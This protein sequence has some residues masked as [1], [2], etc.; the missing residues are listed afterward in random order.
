M[1]TKV[2]LLCVLM[3]LAVA[4]LAIGCGDDDSS[5]SSSTDAPAAADGGGG[6]EALLKQ[7][8]DDV[9]RA[10]ADPVWEDYAPPA[11]PEPKAGLKVGAVTC[12]WAIPACKRSADGLEEAIKAIGWEP[13][14]LDGTAEARNQR[15]AVQTFLNEGVDA[16][17]IESL[18]PNPIA[19]LLKEAADK[20]IP[21]IAQNGPDLGPF[22]GVK[23]M[24]GYPVPEDGERIAAWVA[25]H[26]KGKAKILMISSTDNPILQIIDDSFKS[27]L[28]RFEGVEFVRDTITVPFKDIGPPLEAQARS[29]FQQ[30]P[31]GSIDYV[32]APFGGMAVPLANAAQ[33]AGRDDIKVVSGDGDL[34]TIEF[35]KQ[36]KNQVLNMATSW[37]W[38]SWV[39]VDELNRALNDEPFE[40]GACASTLLDESNV[41]T[42]AEGEWWEPELD[43]KAKFVELWGVK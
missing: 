15:V 4:L 10:K 41:D 2:T 38:C 32:Y 24:A 37:S 28:E 7:A 19:D 33:A 5:S 16:F 36:G 3:G 42:V 30:Y 22:G 18:D 1:K 35:I 39:A 8:A 17:I 43:F 9:A 21:F 29:T 14:V 6:D 26:S 20:G 12:A 27:Y 31:E 23:G 34:Q 13:M 40:G 25:N 11:A